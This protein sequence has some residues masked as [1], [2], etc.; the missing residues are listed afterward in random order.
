MKRIARYLEHWIH[1]WY[2]IF[3]R[4]LKHIFS[5][6]GVLVIF[7]LACLVYPVLYGLIYSKGTLDNMPVAVVDMSG[8]HAS[9]KFVRGL[10]ATRELEIRYSCR[11]MSEAGRLMRDR[12]VNGIVFIPSDYGEDL[13]SS[14]QAGISLYADMSSFIYYKN[15]TTGVNMVMLDEMHDI[16]REHLTASGYD[17]RLAEQFISPIRY[18]DNMPYNRALSYSVFFMSA[19]LLIIIQQTMFFGISMLSGTMREEHRS[20]AV[21]P[22]SLKGRG[23]S[24]T[25]LGRGA[26]YWLIYAAISIYVA[27]LAPRMTGMPQ[28]CPTG[29][30]L[31]LLAFFVSACVVFSF[32]FSTLIRHRETVFVIFLLMSVVCLFLTG[33]SWPEHSFPAFW[34]YFSWLFP[35]TFAVRAFMNMN[36]AGAGLA[37]AEPQLTALT[38]QII[39]YYILS[40]IAAAVE[41]RILKKDTDTQYSTL[42]GFA[43]HSRNAV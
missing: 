21:L 20:F 7:F 42:S 10:D 22:D 12:K 30:I 23:I 25:V 2:R 9:R 15:L 19:I 3:V 38:I 18:E 13:A 11:D 26:A 41:N 40:C 34:K 1:D 31:V 37:M 4:E 27:I 36:T 33:F 17:S 43:A 39:V 35:S 32:T 29:D 14:R 28:N 16:Q 5:D 6:S 24:R 8:S